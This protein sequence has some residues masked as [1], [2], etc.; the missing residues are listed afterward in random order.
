ME[1]ARIVLLAGIS[2]FITCNS[3]PRHI[4]SQALSP[5]PGTPVLGYEVVRTYPHD[6]EGVY[7]GLSIRTAFSTRA[8]DSMASRVCA[9]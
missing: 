2:L 7:Q 3:E 1:L 6:P 9:R 5:A 8:P 4:A